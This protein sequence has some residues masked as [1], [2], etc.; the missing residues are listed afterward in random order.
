MA[1]KIIILLIGLVFLISQPLDVLAQAGPTVKFEA[2]PAGGMGFFSYGSNTG[3][4]FGDVYVLRGVGGTLWVTQSGLWLTAV[5]PP[6]ASAGDE[7]SAEAVLSGVHLKVSFPGTDPSMG[8]EAEGRLPGFVSILKGRDPAGWQTELPLWGTLRYR[9]LY[10]GVDLVIRSTGSGFTWD[11]EVQPGTDVSGL[12]AWI[13]GADGVESSGAGIS[14][15]TAIGEVRLPPLGLRADETLLTAEREVSSLQYESGLIEVYPQ[16]G[17]EPTSD[18]NPEFRLRYSTFFGG[19]DRDDAH[20]LAVDAQGNAY[21][22]GTTISVNFPATAGA[23]Q[24]TLDTQDAFVAKFDMSKTTPTLAYATFLGGS[25]SEKANGIAVDGAY[26][27][28]TGETDSYDFPGDDTVNDVDAFVVKLNATGSGLLYSRII[29]GSTPV[30]LADDYGYAI[31]VENGLAYVTGISYST[32]FPTTDGSANQGAGDAFIVKLNTNGTVAYSKLYATRNLEAGYALEVRDGVAWVTGEIYDRNYQAFLLRVGADGVLSSRIFGGAVDDVGWAIAIDE[33]GDIYLTGGTNS[34]DFPVTDGSTYGGGLYDAFLI[35]FPPSGGHVYA[36]YL[37]GER[38]DQGYGIALDDS[39]GVVVMGYTYSDTFPVSED[40]FQPNYGGNGD[41]FITRYEMDGN[42][43]TIDYSTYLGGSGWDEGYGFALHNGVFAYITGLTQSTDYPVTWNAYKNSLGGTQDAFLTVMAVGEMPAVSIQKQTNGAS[44]DSPQDLLILAGEPVTWTYTVTNQGVVPL[45]GLV[46]SDDQLGTICTIS[47]LAPGAGQ[48]CSKSG[49][50][51]TGVYTNLGSVTGEADLGSGTITVSAADESHYFGAA[52]AAVMVKLTN[53]EDS[54]ETP[55]EFLEV[56]ANVLWEYVV[57]NNGN[58]TLTGVV[59]VDDKGVSVSCSKTTLAPSES[60]TCSGSGTATAGQYAN[61]GTVTGVPPVGPNV[62]ASDMSHYFGSAPAISMVKLTNDTLTEAPEDLYILVDDLVTWTY[63]LENT[64]NVKLTGISVVDDNGTPGNPG[65][66]RTAACPAT[67]LEPGGTTTCTLSGTAIKGAYHNTA[68]VTA[69]PPVGSDV[70]DTADS[71]YFGADPDAAIQFLVN[72]Q[73]ANSAPGVY[74]EARTQI[75]L[76][77]IVT[78]TGNV[79]LTELVV[80]DSLGHTCNITSLAVGASSSCQQRAITAQSGQ[81]NET[82][83]VSAAPPAGLGRIDSDPDPIYYFGVVTGI[84]LEKTTNGQDADT[85]PGPLIKVGTTINWAYV[86]TNTSNITITNIVVTD[87][88][89]GEISC[90]FTTLTAGES[91]TCTAQG[92]ATAGQ[93]ENIGTVTAA[94]SPAEFGPLT[95]SDPSHYYGSDAGVEIKKL[96]NGVD[97][98]V[99]P[100]PF[101]LVGDEVV[102][103]YVITNVGNVEISGILVSDSDSSLEIVCPQSELVPGASMDCIA[104]GT[105]IKGEYTNTGTVEATPEGFTEK[106][107]A[108]DV[109]GY[110]GADPQITIT[111]YTNG[112]DAKEAPGPY[113][114]VGEAV[115]FTYQVSNT[116]TAF[117][118]TNIV[119][120]DESG[121][122]PDCPKTT[123]NPGEDMECQAEGEAAVGQQ[124]SLGKVNAK[125]VVQST[126]VVLTMVQASDISH[127]YGVITG[128][129]IEKLTNGLDADQ[130][131]GPLIK[132][133]QPITWTYKVTNTGNVDL[134]GVRLVDDQEGTITCPATIAAGATVPCTKTGT[135]MEGQYSNLGTVTAIPPAGFAPVT[136]SDSSHYYGSEAG[137]AIKKLTNDVDIDEADP[138]YILV[139]D[140]VSWT[141]VVTNIGNLGLTGVAVTDSDE[142]LVISC[143]EPTLAPGAEM[144]CTASGT[145]TAGAYTNTGYVEGTPAGFAEKVQN[146]HTS[147]YIGAN[148]SIQITKNINGEHY[149]TPPGL[150]ID[151]DEPLTFTYQVSNP[152]TLYRFTNISVTDDSGLV[153]VCP[154]TTLIPGES[155]TCTVDGVSLAGQQSHAGRVTAKVLVHATSVEIATI[156]NSSICHYYGGTGFSIFLPLILR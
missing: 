148:P 98:D 90:P 122:E 142:T 107:G 40:A 93:Y 47:A 105:A 103:T 114:P 96:T 151:V 42:T 56:G 29:G 26:A 25:G 116:E 135:A 132:I 8:L 84:T 70:T 31:D 63:A 79:P 24:T 120:T 119:V 66:D 12:R 28:V 30:G 49:T 126:Q 150:K 14:L 10:P 55:G 9:Q 61:K 110:F 140:P 129:N 4:R 64:G 51:G 130:A 36:T 6:P 32:D 68:T 82:A 46:V 53:G 52:P 3:G 113:I 144:T 94:T 15:A 118:F 37:G 136:D 62:T 71:Y 99:D 35:K 127:Y 44:P 108:S 57:T 77:Y 86:V 139:G 155:M 38:S 123:L 121:L 89:E 112:E 27:Y 22:A 125:A 145:A 97:I 33:R 75:N 95:A 74:V 5:E 153:P 92:T 85:S 18:I 7:T 102:W 88:Q 19:T 154:K 91:K 13:Q 67:T 101:I 115:T 1:K 54:N 106:V 152:E 117:Q 69:T 83:T 16:A 78:N 146:S 59:V 39:G 104:E 137:V 76:D 41:I 128:I 109:S 80:S 72:G 73:D 134:T 11:F 111:K 21:L 23:F 156:Q 65:D 138:P 143:P 87:D 58:V 100:P 147:G 45:T 81:I 141:Y 17:S 124:S 34:S 2:P 60:M 48:V 43:G 20:D 149:P 131:P 50:A 133:G